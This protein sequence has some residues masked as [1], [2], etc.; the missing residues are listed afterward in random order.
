M[1]R[2]FRTS[3]AEAPNVRS[4]VKVEPS[5]FPALSFPILFRSFGRYYFP[6]YELLVVG[7]RKSASATCGER[8]PDVSAKQ[9]RHRA[10]RPRCEDETSARASAPSARER[11]VGTDRPH[12][13]RA[14]LPETL[15]AREEAQRWKPREKAAFNDPRNDGPGPT[16]GASVSRPRD[17]R[18]SVVQGR[19]VPRRAVAPPRAAVPVHPPAARRRA[20]HRQ[21]GSVRGA[22]RKNALSSVRKRKGPTRRRTNAD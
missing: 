5:C 15:Q 14:R 20:A 2:I 12:V 1:R 17:V 9:G 6:V 22:S 21:R 7:T 19:G 10:P 3:R 13:R 11:T 8:H 16:L 4:A 18:E